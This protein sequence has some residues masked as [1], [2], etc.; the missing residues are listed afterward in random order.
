[1]FS[2]RARFI[3]LFAVA[4]SLPLCAAGVPRPEYPQPQFERAQWITLNGTWH[5]AFDDRDEGL[6]EHWNSAGLK[7]P[8][9]IVVPYCFESKLSGIGDTGF[10][11]A[12]WY[13]RSFTLPS[14]WKGKHVLLHFGAVYYQASVWLNGQ[15]LG[16]HEGGNVPFSFDTT[17]ALKP[18]GNTIVVRAVNPPT[19]RSIARGKQ[20]WE[21]QPKSIFYTRT[22]GIWQPVWLEATG[23]NHLAYVH[24]TAGQDGIAHFEGA[25][26]L[27]STEP[28]TFKVTILDGTTEIA[29]AETQTQARPGVG[30]DPHQPAQTLVA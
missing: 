30:R 26:A 27:R 4:L 29:T 11:A 18:G 20:Y 7:A 6:A 24:I 16:S 10:H 8:R 21:P 25:L 1:M 12:I 2:R 13:Q 19:D 17:D 9:D 22:S 5:F 14:A 28:L 23:D 3:A 15:F